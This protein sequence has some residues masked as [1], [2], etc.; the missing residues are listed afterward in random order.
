VRGLTAQSRQVR[1]GVDTLD[2]LCRLRADVL[3]GT[4]PKPLEL[5]LADLVEA[6]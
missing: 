1:M 6:S 5:V 2:E 4:A 3:K